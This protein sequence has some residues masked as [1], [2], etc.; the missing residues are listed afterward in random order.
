M[1]EDPFLALLLKLVTRILAFNFLY[2]FIMYK[3][4]KVLPTLRDGFT[5]CSSYA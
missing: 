4:I 3:T 5:S 2:V 1:S